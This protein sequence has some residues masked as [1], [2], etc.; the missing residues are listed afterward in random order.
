MAGWRRCGRMTLVTA[1]PLDRRLAEALPANALYA[2]GGRVRDEFRAILDPTIPPPKDLDYVVTGLTV[3]EL[4]A[5]LRGVGRVNV[6]GA[7]FAVVKLSALEGDADLA[8]PRR[9]QSTGPGHRDFVVQSGPEITIEEDLGRRDFRMNM[10]ARRIGDDEI[11]D[12]FGGVRD[13]AAHRIDIVA[14]QTFVE[15]PLRLL[16]AAQ[17]AA[18]FGFELSDEARSGMTAAAALVRTVSPERVCEEL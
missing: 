1:H 18:R 4:V 17:F 15:D 5:R 9:E 12:P 6:V 3:D 10:I 8:L 14:P 2:V 7:S 16:C 13:I 11:V